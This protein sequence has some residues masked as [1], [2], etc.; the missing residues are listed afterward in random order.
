MENLIDV[1]RAARAHSLSGHVRT[2]YEREGHEALPSAHPAIIHNAQC[3][4][5]LKRARQAAHDLG[6]DPARIERARVEGAREG[7]ADAESMTSA[8]VVAFINMFER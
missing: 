6:I 3:W 8:E 2:R 7:I 1:A 5:A 4:D